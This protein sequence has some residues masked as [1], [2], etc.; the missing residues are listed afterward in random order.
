ME[1]KLTQQNVAE[2]LG[3]DRTTY[4]VY[5]IGSSSP[6]L[7]SL[8]KLSQIYNVTVDYLIG[9]E[10]KRT[11]KSKPSSNVT[12]SS[13]VDPIA[14]LSKDEKTLLM[15]YRIVDDNKKDDLMEYI[16]NYAKENREEIV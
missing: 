10:E 12:V 4:T 6:S 14:Y 13:Y 3:V 1:H 2:I 15:C 9:A 7:E 11:T 8:C 5:E 16:K